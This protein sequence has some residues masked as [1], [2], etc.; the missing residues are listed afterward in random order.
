M[1][2]SKIISQRTEFSDIKDYPSIIINRNACSLH[3]GWSNSKLKK[4]IA[5]ENN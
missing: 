1:S 3:Y 5:A 2:N 4:F